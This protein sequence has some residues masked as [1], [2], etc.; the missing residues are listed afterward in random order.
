MVT[1]ED[2]YGNEWRVIKQGSRLFYESRWGSN[3]PW[4]RYN[5]GNV[6]DSIKE[7]L[8]NIK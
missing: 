8:R 6:P 7:E 1:V 2:I 4:K 3:A 5:S